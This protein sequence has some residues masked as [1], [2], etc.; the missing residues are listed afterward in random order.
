MKSTLCAA[1][2][3]AIALAAAPLAAQEH[4]E[5]PTDKP[6]TRQV[7]LTKDSL[8]DAIEAWVNE[9]SKL[10]GGYF[11]LY[12]TQAKKPLALTLDHVHRDRLASLGNDVYFACADFKEQG[13]T[14]YDID[15]FMRDEDG[16]LVPTDVSVHK[17]AGNPRYTWAEENGVWVKKPVK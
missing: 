4:P 8:G 6:M 10:L 14:M 1:L 9:Q 5:H 3:L 7:E 2:A 17:E 13:G 15:V 11:L 16:K 12:D